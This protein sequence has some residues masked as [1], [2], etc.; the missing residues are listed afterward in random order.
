RLRV[1]VQQGRKDARTPVAR[2]CHGHHPLCPTTPGTVREDDLEWSAGNVLFLHTDGLPSRW[3]PPSDPGTA[4]ADPAVT[5]AVTIRDA[6]S[7]ARPVRDDTAVAVL[8]STP[9][10]HS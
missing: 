4:A 3:A 1:R 8:T 10:D 7:A 2:A 6:G 5:A 9:P